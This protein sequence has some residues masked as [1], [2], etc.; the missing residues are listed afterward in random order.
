MNKKSGLLGKFFLLI[1]V[2]FLFTTCSKYDEGPNLS[3]YS[4]GKRVQGTWYFSR[5]LYNDVDSTEQ[6]IQGRIE[7]LLGE[8]SGKDWG[9]YT[10]MIKPYSPDPNDMKLG[11]WK[12]SPEKDSIQMVVMAKNA[13]DYDTLKWK[14]KRLAYDE[15]WMER[16]IDEQTTLTWELWKWVF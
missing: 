1:G 4:R 3:L 16:Q 7:F 2:V 8:G 5:V 14:I 15:W 12:F 13:A 6:Y 9:L 10:W 11:G